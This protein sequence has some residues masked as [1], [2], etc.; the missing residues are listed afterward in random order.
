L[1]WVKAHWHPTPIACVHTLRQKYG[2]VYAAH[3]CEN[4]MPLYDMDFTEPIALVFGNEQNGCSPEMVN[5][6]DG[7]IMI[8]Q[9]GMVQSLNISVACAIILFEAFR[10]K[11]AAGHYLTPRLPENEREA[12]LAEWTDYKNI[13][14]KKTRKA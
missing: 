8:P 9:V 12:I 3:L 11:T 1:K 14:D 10:Q 4:A 5:A 7:S 6:C 2:R 13:H